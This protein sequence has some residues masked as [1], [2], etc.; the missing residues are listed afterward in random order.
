[1][2]LN[3]NELCPKTWNIK[4]FNI[5]LSVQSS[6]ITE[7]GIDNM[8]ETFEKMANHVNLPVACVE[9]YEWI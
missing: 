7:V 1:M 3:K 4:D 2:N 8:Q 6:S 9:F 5:K